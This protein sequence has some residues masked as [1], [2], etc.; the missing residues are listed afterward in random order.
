MAT[1]ESAARA[2]HAHV[3]QAEAMVRQGVATKSD[4]LLASVRA[5]EID[6]QLAEATG[7]VQTAR[8]QLAVLLGR[9]GNVDADVAA[10]RALPS[11]ERIR[12]VVAGDTAAQTAQPRA[13]V[14]AAAL[15]LDAARAEDRATVIRAVHLELGCAALRG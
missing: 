5:G 3:A 2:A 12:I 14:E 4:A 8:R 11:A 13:D 1:I 10:T 6:A 9:T 15:G 7:A